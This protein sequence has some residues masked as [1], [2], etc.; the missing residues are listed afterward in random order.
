MFW[1]FLALKLKVFGE[2][3]FVVKKR[4]KKTLKMLV[5]FAKFN[6]SVKQNYSG[7]KNSTLVAKSKVFQVKPKTF[8]TSTFLKSAPQNAAAESSTH[9]FL[10][11]LTL[12]KLC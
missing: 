4:S 11:Y 2:F 12:I 6:H 9:F 3:L 5:R 1:Q 10:I 7:S 8:F